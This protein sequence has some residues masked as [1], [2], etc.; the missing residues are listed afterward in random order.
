MILDRMKKRSQLTTTSAASNMF[1]YR[2]TVSFSDT[3]A[4]GVVYF[5]RIFDLAHRAYEAML[6]A[7][8]IPLRGILDQAVYALPIVSAAGEFKQPLRV[9][10]ELEIAVSVQRLAQ[11]SFALHY[12]IV[13]PAQQTAAPAA[14]LTTEHVA[15]DRLEGHVIPLPREVRAALEGVSGELS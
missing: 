4:A 1:R 10:D 5:A 2:L 6:A 13:V 8:R 11:R 3:D 9:G 14:L 12:S 15:I 7:W